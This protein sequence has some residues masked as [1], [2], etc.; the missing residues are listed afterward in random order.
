VSEITTEVTN[1]LADANERKAQR[2]ARL[3][4]ALALFA[5]RSNWVKRPK[6]SGFFWEWARIG[7]LNDPV[8]IAEEALADNGRT[9]TGGATPVASALESRVE[10]D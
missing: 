2:I 10:P 5:D 7:K 4:S 3:E 9:K 6:G 8:K 1:G